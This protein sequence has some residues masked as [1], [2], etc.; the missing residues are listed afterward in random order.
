MKKTRFLTAIILFFCF[1]LSETCTKKIGNK[2]VFFNEN[3]LPIFIS[4]CTQSKCHNSQD[5]KEGYDLS[6][7]EG[8]MKGIVAKH[9]L[10]SE[11]YN[12]IRGSNPSMPQRPYAKLSTESVEL[13]KLWINMGAPNSFN[14]TSCD[15]TAVTFNK[16]INPII[17]TWCIGCHN[18]SGSGAGIDLS[19]Y[20]GIKSSIVSGRFL[21]S[22]KY[23]TGY[24]KMP[25]NSTQ[26][27]SC[28]IAVIQKWI[29][30]GY[31]NN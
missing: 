13:I 15:S 18:G 20:D 31:P 22:I 26:L 11:V 25:K 3:I 17:K 5:K 14:T 8:I 24:S 10:Q 6:N 29:R 19:T 7:Y 28:N 4:N 9:P 30:E 12:T 23:S 1:F 2:D 16:T 27:S 21:G